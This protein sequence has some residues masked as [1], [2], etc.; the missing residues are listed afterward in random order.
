MMRFGLALAAIAAVLASPPEAAAQRIAKPDAAKGETSKADPS[1]AY[2][3]DALAKGAKEGPAV[4]AKAAV[5]CTTTGLAYAGQGVAK[6][7]AT[8]KD[9]KQ[10]VYEVSCSEGLGYTL[11]ETVGSGTVAAFDCVTLAGSPGQV[12]CRLPANLDLK[13]QLQPL[14]T[15]SGR[16][17]TVSDGRAIGSTKSGESF[18]EVACQ[19]AQGLVVTTTASAKPTAQE[20]AAVLGSSLECKL[21]S[22]EQIEAAQKA[23]LTALIAKS[24]RTCSVSGTRT[25]G[26]LT[27]GDDLYEVAC[28]ST[29]GFMIQASSDGSKVTA[30]DCGKA[31]QMFQ[32]GCTLTNAAVAQTQESAT[33][34]RLA[35]ASGFPCDVSKYRFIGLDAKTKS[36]LVELACSNRSDGGL[37]MF[38]ADNSPGKVYDCVQAG[39]LGQRCQFSSPTAVYNKYTQSLA[40]KGKTT[41]KVSDARWLGRFETQNTELIETACADGAPGWVVEV[42]QRQAVKNV[43][44]CGQARANMSVT[45]QLA[46]NVKK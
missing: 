43:Y 15:A 4:V 25:V 28:G 31:E 44:T 8:K 2:D 42:D 30:V 1:K 23:K 24:G 16:T 3:K 7:P 29:G 13:A 39:G 35:K 40:A 32:G 36:E 34:T 6:D 10:N 5:K 45:C 17:C 37:A 22:K 9:I 33:Y 27:G 19:G 14:A 12:K 18:Y 20:C 11:I 41:C 38:P 21:T 26:R 46:S